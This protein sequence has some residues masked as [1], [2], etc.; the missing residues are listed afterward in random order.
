MRPV[1]VI[2]EDLKDSLEVRLVENQSSVSLLK[3]RTCCQR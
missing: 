1:V 2:D 3:P